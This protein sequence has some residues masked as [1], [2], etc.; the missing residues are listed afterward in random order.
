MAKKFLC[1]DGGVKRQKGQQL[2][3][4]FFVS[5]ACNAG[6]QGVAYLEA[7]SLATAG[8]LKA[9]HWL[10][11]KL[12]PNSRQTGAVLRV[13]AGLALRTERAEWW[14][15]QTRQ[16]YFQGNSNALLLAAQ[17]EVGQTLDLNRPG[18]FGI[19]AQT[20]T[21]NASVLGLGYRQDVLDTLQ[22]GKL[23]V[24]WRPHFLKIHDYQHSQAEFRLN[25]STNTNHLTGRLLRDGTRNYGFLVNEKPDLGW[26]AGLD[27]KAHWQLASGTLALDA[28][29]LLSYLR[30]STLHTS[31]RT[32]QVD[33]IAGELQVSDVP[34]LSGDYGWR[35]KTER[36]PLVWQLNWQPA[37]IAGL[38]PGLMGVGAVTR[39]RLRYGQAWGNQEWW[40][41]TV[42]TDNWSVGV[43]GK[44]PPHFSWRLEL[45]TDR[46]L[47]APVLSS[48]RLR[49]DW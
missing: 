49:Y 3:A 13:D 17:D 18:Y 14:L 25:N 39:W 12:E 5:A 41:Q 1:T 24:E 11:E 27:L 48:L 38:Q 10:P 35:A 22:L 23:E 21:L 32:Y 36:L 16:A 2:L 6:A 43:Q 31:R 29:N 8:Q 7:E 47:A 33:A 44:W 45:S 28:R 30:F 4:L 34:S 37:A 42:Q 9:Q 46:R 15:G 20:W 40:V 19:N 26:G